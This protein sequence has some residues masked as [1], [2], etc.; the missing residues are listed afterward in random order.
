MRNRRTTVLSG[1][2]IENA[3]KEEAERDRK[4]Q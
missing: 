4:E 1:K 2:A 3:L